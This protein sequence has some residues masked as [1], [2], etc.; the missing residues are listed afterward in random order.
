M[1][2][3]YSKNPTFPG[4]QALACPDG[5]RK[6][7]DGGVDLFRMRDCPIYVEIDMSGQVDLIWQH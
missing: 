3:P 4:F 7:F 5:E 6:N 1:G 2:V